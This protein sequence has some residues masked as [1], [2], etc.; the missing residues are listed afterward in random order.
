VNCLERHINKQLILLWIRYFN[1]LYSLHGY[2]CSVFPKLLIFLYFLDEESLL[3]SL[4]TIFL[5]FKMAVMKFNK[6]F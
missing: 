4:G 2:C 6:G 3:G 1:G 5:S